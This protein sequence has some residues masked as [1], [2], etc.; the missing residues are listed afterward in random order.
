MSCPD[1]LTDTEADVRRA[2]HTAIEAVSED[3][4]GRD[5]VEYSDLG[6]DEAHQRHQRPGLENLRT[7]VKGGVSTLIRLLAPFAP[8]LA[9]ELWHQFGVSDSIHRQSWPELDPTA[10]VQDSVDLVIQVKGKVRGT[11]QVPSDADKE[12]WNNSPLPVTSLPNGWR[13]NHLA[14]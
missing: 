11:I 3:L 7:P 5:S 9:E 14:A 6:A 2:V 13:D 12:P 10:L 1:A 8:H 4:A